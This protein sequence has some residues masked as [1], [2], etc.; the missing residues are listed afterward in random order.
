MDRTEKIEKTTQ[1]YL[2]GELSE[3][4]QTAVE[5]EYFADRDRFE[6]VCALENDLI[7]D[8]VRGN[9]ASGER[10][11]FE[12]HYLSSPEKV[13][14]VQFSGSM[15]Q[16]LYAAAATAPA[17]AKLPQAVAPGSRRTL[18]AMLAR[19]RL[20]PVGAL[21]ALA[22]VLTVTVLLLGFEA[23]RL[24]RELAASQQTI[25]AQSQTERDLE[26]QLAE[27]RAD[28][29]RHTRDLEA[30]RSQHTAEQASPP[31]DKLS[32]MVAVFTLK[33][34]LIRGIGEPQTL[35][36][37]PDA[38][39]VELRVDLG[40][41]AFKKYSATLQTPE[42]ASVVKQVAVAVHPSQTGARAVIRVPAK[43][44]PAGDY[45]LRVDGMNPSGEAVEVSDCYFR[46]VKNG[47]R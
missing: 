5:S 9:L 21:A 15:Q 43:R 25:A 3:P 28:A 27:Q 23:A 40:H 30:F 13:R 1:R 47:A 19:R 41:T 31:V 10:E 16:S 37:E 2:L 38:D 42:G 26:R 46:V 17:R 11:Q 35:K 7:D 18:A 20:T 12:R 33:S 6:E 8:Y 32:P 29:E 24:R 4:E 14:R 45:V 44:L 39:V 22:V 34:G 36:I